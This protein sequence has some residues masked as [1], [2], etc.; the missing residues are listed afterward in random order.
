MQNANQDN[1]PFILFF[2]TW[3]EHLS[4]QW[5]LFDHSTM[6]PTRGAGRI[7]MNYTD[8]F[9]A[10]KRKGRLIKRWTSNIEHWTLNVQRPTS[11]NDVATLRQFI[12][13]QNTLFKIRCWTF[14]VHFFQSLLGKNNLAL[15]GSGIRELG[16][17]FSFHDF[18]TINYEKVLTNSEWSELSKYSSRNTFALWNKPVVR[19]LQVWSSLNFPEGTKAG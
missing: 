10:R 6:V 12:N 16:W 11:N 2:C 8:F 5:K 14:D 13:W 15:M 17:S 19:E 9:T 1:W 18:F 7:N 4:K 3:P